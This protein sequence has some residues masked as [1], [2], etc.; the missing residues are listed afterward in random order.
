MTKYEAIINYIKSEISKGTIKPG[1]K[2]PSIRKICVQFQCSKVTVVKAYDLLEKEHMVYCMPKSGHYLIKN[3]LTSSNDI[4]TK[5]ID[6]STAAPDSSI[7]PYEEFQ[8]CIN[9]AMNLYKENLFSNNNTQ[10]FE[11]LILAIV[12]QLQNYQVFAKKQCVFITTGSQQAINILTKMDFPNNQKNVL[13][14]Q[15]TYHGIIQSIVLNNITA[16]GIK[17]DFNGINL[18]ELEKNFKYNNIKFFYIIPRF[19][20]PT[21]FSYSNEEKKQILN[22]CEKYNVYIIEDDYLADLE[23]NK[24]SDPMY[25]LD[26]S[27]RVIYLKSYSKILLP[28]LRVSAVVLPELLLDTFKKYKIW[29]DLNTPILS[30]GALEI[31]IRSGLFDSH[32]EKLKSVYSKRMKYLKELTKNLSNSNVKWYI[33]DSGFFANFEI[34]NDMNIKYLIKNLYSKNV[35]LRDTEDSFLKNCSNNKLARLSISNVTDAEIK[36][37]ISMILDEINANII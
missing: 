3:H 37:G 7:L 21:G 30:Q 9:C 5:K 16:F 13:V 18:D 10:G 27:S 32:K 25:A 15:P 23:I 31:Y 2:L 4:I 6:F 17:R 22:L 8:H 29:D 12:K 11:N 35:L 34:T 36:K 20:N 26:S 28:G 24:K 14:E 19:H 33:P 1:K